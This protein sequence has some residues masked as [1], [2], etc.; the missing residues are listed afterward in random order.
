MSR[1]AGRFARAERRCRVRDL[2]L[3]LLSDLPRRGNPKL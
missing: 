1:M 3:G 2:M